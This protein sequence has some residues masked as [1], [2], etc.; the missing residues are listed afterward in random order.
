LACAMDSLEAFPVWKSTLDVDDLLGLSGDDDAESSDSESSGKE[1]TSAT[2][3][4]KVV[5]LRID[6]FLKE[7]PM[8]EE[9]RRAM[10]EVILRRLQLSR[11]ESDVLCSER[12]H[13]VSFVLA[14]MEGV[15]S[16]R[17][18][19]DPTSPTWS[20][21][22]GKF[23][24]EA[25]VTC[26]LVLDG[27]SLLGSVYIVGESGSQCW[28][29]EARLSDRFGSETVASLGGMTV[30]LQFLGVICA[31]PGAA[32]YAEWLPF[33]LSE[34]HLRPVEEVDGVYEG[35]RAASAAATLNLQAQLEKHRQSSPPRNEG[36]RGAAPQRT[37]APERTV[38]ATQR[39]TNARVRMPGSKGPRR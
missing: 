31:D 30:L 21:H 29:D 2:L 3:N 26:E 34:K 16:Q 11:S 39:Q 36:A 37:R 22:G 13:S 32:C 18:Q 6:R 10:F 28:A 35:L 12:R 19:A 33:R 5:Q 38:A 14:G 7:Q 23:V 8:R 1:V 20:V 25:N 17:S 15:Y 27:E 9:K 4:D 24:R